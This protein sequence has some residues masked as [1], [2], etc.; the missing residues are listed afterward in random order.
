MKK[1]LL[2][3]LLV[4]NVVN[5]A[6][7][8]IEE[9]ITGLY[10]AFFDRAPDA[11]GLRWWIQQGNNSDN[12]SL[13]L[14]DLAS[15]FAQHPSFDRAYGDLDNRAF[16]EEVY[17]N[18][19]GRDGDREGI[20]YWT[21]RL[22][23][24]PDA[25]GYLSRS[26]FVAEFVGAVLTFDRYDPQYANL[27]EEELIAAQLRQN[28]LTNKVEAALA[29]THR[30]GEKTNVTDNNNPENDP[31]YLA[32]IK[33]I[34]FINEEHSTVESVESLLANIEN[35]SEPISYINQISLE[36]LQIK[37]ESMDIS[38]IGNVTDKYLRD[39]NISNSNADLQYIG[40]ET[41]DYDNKNTPLALEK[42]FYYNVSVHYTAITAYPDGLNFVFVLV[43]S[44]DNTVEDGQELFSKII[45]TKRVEIDEAGEGTLVADIYV[46]TDLEDGLYTLMIYAIDDEKNIINFINKD[47]HNLS[48]IGGCYI[49]LQTNE[50]AN[51]IE[52][53]DIN[54]LHYIDIP[55]IDDF[56]NG[57]TNKKVGATSL[58]LVNTSNEPK[59]VEISG[60][61][62]LEDGSSVDLMLLDNNDGTIKN[63]IRYT[64]PAYQDDENQSGIYHLDITYYLPEDIYSDIVSKVP[65]MSKEENTDGLNGNIKW[66]I[67]SLD[68]DIKIDDNISNNIQ[69]SK[70]VNNYIISDAATSNQFTLQDFTHELSNSNEFTWIR[71]RN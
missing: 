36:E 18:M 46:G 49:Q 54:S 68:D 48:Q 53:I 66:I 15:R 65:D 64:I 9:K 28:L 21:S 39:N 31:A 27:S 35:I 47:I 6:E 5:A 70:Y 3:V 63:Y 23:L 61:M 11:E 1:L 20:N 44:D 16:V 25:N 12:P 56:V 59:D 37:L 10:V 14:K 57:H 30:L 67:N 52:V 69:L 2:L 45:R 62:Q 17:R 33:I 40:S 26:D 71:C 42:G 51:R 22:N 4:V 34:S 29:F 13:V 60:I 50:N 8:T 24:S 58:T 19:L 41:L 7:V 38:L 43:K 32:S 55:Y